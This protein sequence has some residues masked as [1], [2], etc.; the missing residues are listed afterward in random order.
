VLGSFAT[1]LQEKRS[2]VL[3]V[4]TANEVISLPPELLRRGRF[5]EIFFVDLPDE[6][7]RAEILAIHLR[8]HG[9]DPARFSVATAAR[10]TDHFSG[11]ELE[12]V[13]V[14][15]L[16]RAFAAGRDVADDDL[17]RSASEIVP[18]YRTYEE[19]VKALRTWA[20]DRARPASRATG[21]VDLLRGKPG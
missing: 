2:P 1:W 16:Y 13:V 9:R 11:A 6:R 10:S 21:V 19:R 7:A 3:V 18:L 15:A 8:R 12:Q 5:D 20:R 4:A 14:A 17:R